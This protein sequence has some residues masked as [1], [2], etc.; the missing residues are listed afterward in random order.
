MCR[1]LL[2]K[3]RRRRPK[4][5]FQLFLVPNLRITP[6]NGLSKWFLGTIMC[7]LIEFG[8]SCLLAEGRKRPEKAKFIVCIYN[9][10]RRSLRRRRRPLSHDCTKTAFFISP[11]AATGLYLALPQESQAHLL[12]ILF[13]KS[14]AFPLLCQL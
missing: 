8:C 9:S 1:Y 12:S 14:K 10:Q 11:L 5:M 7:F 3:G 6:H 4:N 13:A 2:R